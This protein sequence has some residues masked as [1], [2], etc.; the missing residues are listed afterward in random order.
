MSNPLS[1]TGRSTVAMVRTLVTHV[2][3]LAAITRVELSKKYAGSVLGASW[4]VL[5]PALLRA[6]LADVAHDGKAFERSS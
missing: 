4:L 1:V 2:R 5:Q 3:L 6:P